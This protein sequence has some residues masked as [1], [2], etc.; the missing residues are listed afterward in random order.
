MI[1]NHSLDTLPSDDPFQFGG[2]DGGDGIDGGDW[3]VAHHEKN[4]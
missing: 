4:A 3:V 2:V 1:I